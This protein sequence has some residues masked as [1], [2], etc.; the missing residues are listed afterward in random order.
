MGTMYIHDIN[1]YIYIWT[2]TTNRGAYI[3]YTWIYVVVKLVDLKDRI[4]ASGQDHIAVKASIRAKGALK[5][6][7]TYGLRYH[8]PFRGRWFK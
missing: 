8:K 4:I 7:N 2:Y 3:S 5:T 1:I 6:R